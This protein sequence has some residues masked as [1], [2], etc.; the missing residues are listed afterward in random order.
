MKTIAN[1]LVTLTDLAHPLT[2]VAITKFDFVDYG[3]KS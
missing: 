2:Y 3:I 1:L